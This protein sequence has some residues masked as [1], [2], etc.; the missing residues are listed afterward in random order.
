MIELISFF[1]RK[2]SGDTTDDRD[3]SYAET[4]GL[5]NSLCINLTLFS[6][7]MIFFEA[8]RHMKSTYLKRSTKKFKVRLAQNVVSSISK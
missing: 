5:L 7:F 8:N 1:N 3:S 2:L 4:E 6:F